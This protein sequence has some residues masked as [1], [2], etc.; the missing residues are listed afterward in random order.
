ML[1]VPL[2]CWVHVPEKTGAAMTECEIL[3]ELVPPDPVQEFVAVYVPTFVGDMLVEP[4]VGP[5]DRVPEGVGP[6]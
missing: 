6:V 1:Y 2:L 4:L 3:A 5:D